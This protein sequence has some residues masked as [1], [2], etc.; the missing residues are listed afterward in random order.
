MYNTPYTY[1][2]PFETYEDIK[3]SLT[4]SPPPF[5]RGPI[6]CAE[7][8]GTKPLVGGRREGTPLVILGKLNFVPEG[9]PG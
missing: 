6:A 1:T 7:K 8:G 5:I 3:L 2:L 4:P 9:R